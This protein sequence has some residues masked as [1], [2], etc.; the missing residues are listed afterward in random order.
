[1]TLAPDLDTARSLEFFVPGIPEPQGSK[2][3]VGRGKATRAI[4]DNPQL[5]AW[6]TEVSN[7][8][9]R[10]WGRDPLPPRVA[11]AA[12][13]TFVFPRPNYHFGARGVA[14]RWSGP[15]RVFTKPDLDK[16]VRAVC[17]AMQSGGVVSNDSQIAEFVEPFGK[18]Y[19]DPGQ[20]WGSRP[21]VHVRLEW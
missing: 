20:P 1:V 6:R 3:V 18:W 10:L 21:G 19:A 11:V 7:A 9:A 4:E 13:L 14:P 2:T 12:S 5:P 16:L 8:A 15:Q 17:D